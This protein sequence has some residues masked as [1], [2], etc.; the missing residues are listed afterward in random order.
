[1]VDVER[2]S[3]IAA[4]MAGLS[5]RLLMASP[6]AY[7]NRAGI[8]VAVDQDRFG[9]SRSIG[10]NS[11]TFKVGPRI[12]R[13]PSLPWNNTASNQAVRH[14]IYIMNKMNSGM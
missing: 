2:R 3:F 6:L 11:T 10:L 8:K 9:Q 14:S 1:M 4:L 5:S 13:A 12:P 7:A